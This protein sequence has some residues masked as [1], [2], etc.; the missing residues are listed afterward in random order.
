MAAVELAIERV[1]DHN[2]PTFVIE[3]GIRWR[4]TD[5]GAEERD[6]QVRRALADRAGDSPAPS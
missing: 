5:P 2:R 6:A 1:Q 3:D 4:W